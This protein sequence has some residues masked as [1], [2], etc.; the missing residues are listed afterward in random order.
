[1]DE[2]WNQAGFLRGIGGSLLPCDKG[3]SSLR[4]GFSFKYQLSL[5]VAVFYHI[6]AND[7]YLIGG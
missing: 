2:L 1:M 5:Y 7:H 4:R 6:V 3:L